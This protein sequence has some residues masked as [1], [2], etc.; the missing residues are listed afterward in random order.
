MKKIFSAILAFVVMFTVVPCAFADS[1]PPNDI[2]ISGVVSFDLTNRVPQEQEIVLENGEVATIGIV[3]VGPNT[4]GTYENATGEWEI[5]WY[6]VYMNI[7][8]F[9]N[10][11]SDGKI[12]N[13]YNQSH[14]SLGVTVTNS[15]LEYSSTVAR[16]WWD[17]EFQ[18]IASARYN[19]FAEMKGTT[20]YTSVSG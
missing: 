10:I 2:E 14:L 5:Y 6:T 17:Y 7:W 8:Y 15:G 12:T 11:S 13:A 4:R 1:N 18:G 3:P 20:L 16:G 9:I 19:L